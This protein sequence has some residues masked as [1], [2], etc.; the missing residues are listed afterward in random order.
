MILYYDPQAHPERHGL[1]PRLTLPEP[2][3]R[4]MRG[5]R[6][7]CRIAELKASSAAYTWGKEERSVH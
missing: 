6:I 3:E 2:F 7:E 1:L 5:F 4:I